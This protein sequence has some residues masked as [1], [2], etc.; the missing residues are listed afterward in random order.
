MLFRFN[1][2]D[3]YKVLAPFQAGTPR[4]VQDIFAE[5]IIQIEDNTTYSSV[6][7]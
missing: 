2:F 5:V 7:P 3:S 4:E 6:D 1:L